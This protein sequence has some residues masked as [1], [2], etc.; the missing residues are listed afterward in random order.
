MV[1]TIHLKKFQLF[2]VGKLNLIACFEDELVETFFLVDELL[3]DLGLVMFEFALIVDLDL[4]FET[5]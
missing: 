1:L 2:G 3:F 4:F 5:W